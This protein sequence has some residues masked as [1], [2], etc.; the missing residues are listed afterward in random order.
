[1]ERET[2]MTAVLV[3]RTVEGEVSVFLNT[4]GAEDFEPLYAIEVLCMEEWHYQPPC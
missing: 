1:M 4:Q 2:N 3:N